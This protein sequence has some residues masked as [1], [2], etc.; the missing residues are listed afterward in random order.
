VFNTSKL[1]PGYL[2]DNSAWEPRP[3]KVLRSYY[4]DAMKAQYHG[5]G[6]H[7]VHAAVELSLL[8]MDSLPEAIATWLE[9]GMEHQC[10]ALN[11]EIC[12]AE[13]I[14][15]HELDA[16]YRSS[17]VS[18]ILSLNNTIN[19][20]T[21]HQTLDIRMQR[22]RLVRPDLTCMGILLMVEKKSKPAWWDN[23]AMQLRCKEEDKAMGFHWKQAALYLLGADNQQ[24]EA[25]AGEEQLWCFDES[26]I[27]D[28]AAAQD[29]MVD[30]GGTG[31][32]LTFF[33][34][35]RPWVNRGR[36]EPV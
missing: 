22:S 28:V 31:K 20:V 15:P 18:M 29:E 2:E 26:P 19:W 23:P 16:H 36:L 32:V 9:T 25:A 11:V 14:K 27:M 5:L 34:F 24:L 6:P 4:T 21:D 13:G 10:L 1:P 35:L 30:E 17:Y 8:L 12:H 33:H 7:Y 3:V